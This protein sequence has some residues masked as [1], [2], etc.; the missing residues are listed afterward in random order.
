MHFL[1]ITTGTSHALDCTGLSQV[2]RGISVMTQ[3]SSYPVEL[4]GEVLKAE[5]LKDRQHD[6]QV[7]KC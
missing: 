3:Q 7:I 2:E 4:R 5:S 6:S 1:S